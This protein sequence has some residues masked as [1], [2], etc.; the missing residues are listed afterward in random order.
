M[1]ASGTEVLE[2]KLGKLARQGFEQRQ[3]AAAAGRVRRAK[4]LPEVYETGRQTT[5]HWQVA[6]QHDAAE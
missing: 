1:F 2:P 6:E 5:R 3:Y 4:K